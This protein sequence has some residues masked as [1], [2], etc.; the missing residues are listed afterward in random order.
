MSISRP[1]FL[2]TDFGFAGPYVGQMIGAIA[3]LDRRLRVIDLMHDAPRMR[4][5]LAAYLLPAVCRDLPEDAVVVAV[6]DPGVG[7]ARA[8]L[9]LECDGRTF[10]GPDNG[11][12]SRLHGIERLAV[13]DWRPAL[14]SNSFHGRDLFAPVAAMHAQGRAVAAHPLELAAMV[15]HD[16][17]ARLA[18]VVYID[19]YGN[20]MTGIP[21]QDLPSA[22]RLRVGDSWITAAT[23][24]GDVAPGTPF[25]YRNSQGLVEIAANRASAAELLALELGDKIRLDS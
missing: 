24:F 20:C 1:I 15:G 14:L 18:R 5:D 10:I 11:L 19:A 22:H 23:T 25:W 16:W 4:P 13:I 7:G 3:A 21:A 12:L 6:V 17:P 2:F 9:C 8:A